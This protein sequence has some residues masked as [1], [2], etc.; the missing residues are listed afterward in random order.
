MAAIADQF[1][2]KFNASHP[3]AQAMGKGVLFLSLEIALLSWLF[4]PA[5]MQEAAM[6]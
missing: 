1:R 4:Y 3:I 2:K 5:L 6:Q